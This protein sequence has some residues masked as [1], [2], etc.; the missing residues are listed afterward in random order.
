VAAITVP[1]PDPGEAPSGAAVFQV[2]AIAFV[3][4]F[5]VSG[6]WAIDSGLGTNA[7][8]P[9]W[10]AI[11]EILI[12]V[13]GGLTCIVSFLVQGAE[14][15]IDDVVSDDAEVARRLSAEP[16][17]FSAWWLRKRT[18]VLKAVVIVL[19]A[20]MLFALDRLVHG[21]GGGIHSPFV[22]LLTAPAIFGP[23][24][25][26]TW[27]GIA[28]SVLLVSGAV[29]YEID[30]ALFRTDGVGSVYNRWT[31]GVVAL[32]VIFLA[33]LISAA[34]RWR[35]AKRREKLQSNGV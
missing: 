17:G 4:L 32:A 20:A 7:K 8:M 2:G 9:K 14:I 6:V 21:T 10:F 3:N 29:A 25:S 35:G 23:F 28:L 26:R 22:P 30:V 12:I 34:Q 18:P 16:Q 27:K 13:L 5:V 33:G 31:Y 11:P 24:L 19:A 15:L 1:A